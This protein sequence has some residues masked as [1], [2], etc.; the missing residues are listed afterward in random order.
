MKPNPF[1][2]HMEQNQPVLKSSP[3][4]PT[5]SAI[6]ELRAGSLN[7]IAWL[8]LTIWMLHMQQGDGYITPPST[9]TSHHESARSL[10][11]GRPKRDGVQSCS[12]SRSNQQLS[13][14]QQQK[15]PQESEF[16]QQ[17]EFPSVE[18]A[19]EMPSVRTFQEAKQ[20]ASEYYPG[21]RQLSENHYVSDVVAAKKLPHIP[22]FGLDPN[23]YGMT[24]KQLKLIGGLGLYTYLE[25]GFPPPP[26][27]LIRDFQTA[28][29]ELYKSADTKPLE[30]ADGSTSFTHNEETPTSIFANENRSKSGGSVTIL[31]FAEG[32]GAE[33]QGNLITG[34]KRSKNYVNNIK[35]SG[36]MG[37]RGGRS[38]KQ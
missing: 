13:Q 37:T 29:E 22:E 26:P 31:A 28:I 12:S 14:L 19:S 18:E 3:S 34:G 36:N 20:F 32:E 11:F 30:Q 9:A 21:K 35:E 4:R 8:L 38:G 5:E 15:E 2:I 1:D 7:E 25:K 6:K 24:P 10:L 17:S 27:E 23:D 16:Q 33:G